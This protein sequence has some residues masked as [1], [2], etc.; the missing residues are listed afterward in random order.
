MGMLNV[1][2]WSLLVCMPRTAAACCA[3]LHL[4]VG[5]D[6]AMSG[7]ASPAS[8]GSML[9]LSIPLS[10]APRLSHPS[11]SQ[12]LTGSAAGVPGGTDHRTSSEG[13]AQHSSMHSQTRP[14][15]R[16]AD[17]PQGEHPGRTSPQGDGLGPLSPAGDRTSAY[18]RSSRRSHVRFVPTIVSEVEDVPGSGNLPRKQ[19]GEGSR[20]GGKQDA[21]SLL[22]ITAGLR[23]RS[24][25]ALDMYPAWRDASTLAPVSD[26]VAC[27]PLQVGVAGAEGRKCCDSVQASLGTA[28]GWQLTALGG[29]Y[30]GR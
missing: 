27:E 14:S 16:F 9:H 18:P 2:H 15:V 28:R 19:S 4:Q 3:A 30:A 25:A 12:A 20:H 13:K 8:Q 26:G 21:D 23:G 5:M 22:S 17:S 29:W 7:S 1:Q 24:A 11:S 6:R 10:P